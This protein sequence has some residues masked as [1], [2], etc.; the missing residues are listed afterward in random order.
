MFIKTTSKVATILLPIAL[1]LHGCGGGSSGG[2]GGDA[3]LKEPIGDISGSWAVS[4]RVDARNCLEGIYTDTYTLTLSQ[5]GNSVRASTAAGNFTGTLSGKTLSWSGSFPEDGGTTQASVKMSIAGSCQRA[6][7][8]SSW[9]WSDGVDSCSGTTTIEATRNNPT[10]CNG[11]STAAPRS[12]SDLVA[13]AQS[14]GS[15]RLDWI[16]NADDETGY[17]VQRADTGDGPFANHANL[18]PGS[19]AF[20]DD[21]GLTA[22][23]TYFYRVYATNGGTEQGFSHTAFAT[24]LATAVPAAPGELVAGAVGTTTGRVAWSDNS[25]SESGYLVEASTLAPDAGYNEIARL[26]ENA[27]AFDAALTPGTTYH[28]RVAAFNAEGIS[29]F[30]NVVTIQTADDTAGDGAVE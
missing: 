24:T 25:V 11:K 3:E 2:G 17:V 19:A 22:D 18:P 16:D 30:S 8:S 23:T 28:L 15:I 21:I 27:T 26:P 13:T 5:S 7:G 20:V 6:T 10:G 12:A 14:A 4:E 1:T 29:A 9:K